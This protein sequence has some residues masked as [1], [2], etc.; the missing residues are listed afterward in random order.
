MGLI[1]RAPG[2]GLTA[3]TSL[4]IKGSDPYVVGGITDDSLGKFSLG[5]D[6]FGTDL[7]VPQQANLPP[8]FAVV[9][10]F[11]RNPY[12]GYQPVFYSLGTNQRWELLSY[13][14]NASPT[15]EGETSITI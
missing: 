7:P 2:N 9:K 10:T 15:S 13:G 8:Y 14:N 12:L 6:P 11:V 1:F 4:I 3:G 5:K